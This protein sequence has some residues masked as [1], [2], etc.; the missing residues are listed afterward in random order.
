VKSVER[1]RARELR[2]E[3]GLA[4]KEIAA[5]LDVSS[6]SVS[7]WVRDVKLTAAQEAV[8]R[9]STDLQPATQ[10]YRALKC[11][12]PGAARRRPSGA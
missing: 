7:R 2:R 3:Q 6:S 12:R 10:R 5:A 9:D 8:L 1:E 11:Q 4:I